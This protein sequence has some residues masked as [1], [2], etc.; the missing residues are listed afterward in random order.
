MLH[1]KLLKAT[2]H[3]VLRKN[4][5]LKKQE[6]QG[7]ARAGCPEG[8]SWEPSAA[9]GPAGPWPPQGRLVMQDPAKDQGCNGHSDLSQPRAP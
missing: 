1:F 8:W 3:L 2:W 6:C 4:E 5:I 9:I 7:A